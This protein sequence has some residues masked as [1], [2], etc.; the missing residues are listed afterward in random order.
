MGEHESQKQPMGRC[1]SPDLFQQSMNE[2]F[3]G[4]EYVRAYIKN[5]SIIR[6]KSFEGHIN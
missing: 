1:N 5:L 2:L 4:L 3:N 6:N